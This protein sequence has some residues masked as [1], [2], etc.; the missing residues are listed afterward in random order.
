MYTYIYTFEKFYL[1]LQLLVLLLFEK[2]LLLL[3]LC[4]LLTHL[5]VCLCAQCICMCVCICVCVRVCVEQ[6]HKLLKEQELCMYVCMCVCVFGV[7]RQTSQPAGTAAAE[8]SRTAALSPGN[9]LWVLANTTY[10]RHAPQP[11]QC[12]VLFVVTYE[13]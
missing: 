2:A 1:L 12:R 13:V 4:S 11:V 9:A 6:S 7:Q 3:L 10:V 5:C 8:T